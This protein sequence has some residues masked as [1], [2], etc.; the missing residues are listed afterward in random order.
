MPGESSWRTS[1]TGTEGLVHRDGVGE[2]GRHFPGRIERRADQ[3]SA[4]KKSYE[5]CSRAVRLAGA[6]SPQVLVSA[7]DSH[8]YITGHYALYGYHLVTQV[9]VTITCFTD[10]RSPERQ[11]VTP[12]ATKALLDSNPDPDAALIKRSYVETFVAAPGIRR[13]STPSNWLRA[14][15]VAKQIPN[16]CVTIPNSA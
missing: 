5:V 13:S 10:R 16:N 4:T 2:R 12:I 15:C 1:A 3:A 9:P 8:A 6:V 14:F 11:R 7:I